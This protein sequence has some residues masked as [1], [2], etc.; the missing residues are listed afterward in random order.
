MR[1]N[2]PVLCRHR[3]SAIHS[4][5]ILK[6]SEINDICV[7]IHNNSTRVWNCSQTIAFDEMTIPH[8]KPS[9]EAQKQAEA[10]GNPIPH[11]YIKR[12]PHPNCFIIWVMATKSSSSGLPYVLDLVPDLTIPM[13][14]ARAGLKTVLSRWNYDNSKWINLIG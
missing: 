2:Y 14:S 12:K 4:I 3:F 6:D 7:R 10:A 13:I 1:R 9:Q 8:Q 11:H 5:I